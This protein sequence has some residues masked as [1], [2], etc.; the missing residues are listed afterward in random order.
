VSRARPRLHTD[1]PRL[2][3]GRTRGWGGPASAG[4]GRRR[5][6]GRPGSS[7]RRGAQSGPVQPCSRELARGAPDR[8]SIKPVALRRQRRR[9]AGLGRRRAACSVS[10]TQHGVRSA[11]RRDGLE[12]LRIARP[13]NA[14]RRVGCAPLPRRA[15]RR[16]RSSARLGRHRADVTRTLARSV[17]AGVRKQPGSVRSRS[18]S[19]RQG[20]R[21][22]VPAPHRPVLFFL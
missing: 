17:A 10:R 15:H 19:P 9:H 21:Q 2:R 20:P 8:P 16:P 14:A 1:G 3:R 6:P 11:R 4:R 13:G 5:F 22:A 18:R 7:R 12:S